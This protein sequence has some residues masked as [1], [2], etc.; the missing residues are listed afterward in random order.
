MTPLFRVKCIEVPWNQRDKM[1]ENAQYDV[2]GV[3]M[4]PE[5][6]YYLLINTDKGLVTAHSEYFM[7]VTKLEAALK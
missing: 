4:N 1:S 5:H 2:Y 3:S 7:V 6:S